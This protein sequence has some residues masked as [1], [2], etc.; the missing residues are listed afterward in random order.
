MGKRFRFFVNQSK[1]FQKSMVESHPQLK[2]A[3]NKLV[4]SCPTQTYVFVCDINDNG[5]VRKELYDIHGE[6]Q[7]IWKQDSITRSIFKECEDFALNPTNKLPSAVTSYR[8]CK[9]KFNEKGEF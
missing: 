7:N 1:G 6:A 2:S 5:E 9:S 3:L 8:V 4:K